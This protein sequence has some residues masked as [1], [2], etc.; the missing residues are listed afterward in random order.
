MRASIDKPVAGSWWHSLLLFAL[1]FLLL[2]LPFWW[3]GRTNFLSRAWFNVD[4]LLPLAIASRSRIAA[5]GAL[6]LLWIMDA[7]VSQSLA[8]HFHSPFEFIR[9]IE[10]LPSVNLGGYLSLERLAL[11]VPF[12]AC[13]AGAVALAG[14]VRRP[15]SAALVVLALVAV[16][17]L[18]NG[19]NFL[20]ER[21]MRLLPG[22][23]GGS[24]VKQIVT[25]I[26]GT[27]EDKIEPLAPGVALTSQFDV[28]SWARAHPDRDVLLVLVESMGLHRDVAMRDWLR[29]QLFPVSLAS[30]YTLRE[31][32]VPFHGST[33]S[34]ELRE[35]CGL[36]GSYR[37]VLDAAPS[38]CLPQHLIKNGWQ[39]VGVHGFSRRMFVR[40]IWWPALGLRHVLFGEE[41]TH[42]DQRFCGGAFVGVCDDELIDRAFDQ[43]KTPGRFV[44]A[45]TLSSHLP[46]GSGTPPA[47]L[48]AIC[49]QAQAGDGPCE[50]DA[51]IGVALGA[52]GRDLAAVQGK[53]PLVLVVGDH[54]PPFSIL[55]WRN[56][57]DQ[58]VVPGFALEPKDPD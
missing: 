29:Q 20:W 56:E 24:A 55:A 23:V 25:A 58:R 41:L 15:G 19:S 46:L 4:L 1:A 57:F 18:S 32:D 16:V 17:D 36:T 54:A 47:P 9:S 11:V 12:A 37:K 40:G 26:S 8:W 31:F 53:A 6:A 35:L 52:I 38:G 44:Y 14:R 13:G 49:R 7:A 48:E 43:L 5:V 42:P 50:L 51:T 2:N 27:R 3:L 33:T 39:T 10:F 30:R 28:E 34:A 45:L 21:A 22:N